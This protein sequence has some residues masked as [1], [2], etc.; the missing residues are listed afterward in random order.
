MKLGSLVFFLFILVLFSCGRQEAGLPPPNIVWITSEDNSKHYLELFDEDGVE[1]PNIEMLAEEG[2]IFRHAF[3]NAPVCSVARSTLISGTYSPRTGAQFHRKISKVPLPDSL[4]MFPAYLKEAGYYTANNSK[5]DYN[6]IKNEGVWDESSKTATYRNRRTGQPFFYVHN[7]GVSHESGLHFTAEQMDTTTTGSPAKASKVFPN[8]PETELFKFTNSF[9]RDK[10]QEMDRQVGAVVIQLKED[11]L[12][13]STIIFYFG[14]HGGVLPGS[15]GYLYE[16]GVHIPL[17][18]Y[19]PT[20]YR[21]SVSLPIGSSQDGFVSFIDFGP[22]VLNLAGIQVPDQMD[23]IPFLGAGVSAEQLSHRQLT[24]SYA[25]RFDEKYDMVRAVRKGKFKYIRNYQPFNFDGLM[26]NYRYK[27]LAYQQWDSLY[28]ADA[29]NPV[30]SAFFETKPPEMLYDLDQDPHETNNLA[31]SLEYQNQLS[32]MREQ[33]DQWVKGMPDLS[34]YPEHFLI[35][36]AFENP[37][38]FGRAHQNDIAKYIRTS[39]LALSPFKEVRKELR[40]SLSSQDPWERYWALIGCSTFG[41]EAGELLPYIEKASLEDSELINRARA[42]EYLGLTGQGNPVAVITEALYASEQ[43]AEALLI[44]N[45]IILMQ[46]ANYQFRFQLEPEKI[47]T[48]VK[49][50]AE[51]QRRLEFLAANIL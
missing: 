7:L 44:L 23:G 41:V 5:E 4:N 39:N 51:V 36:N 12:F 26:N 3:S 17:V 19:I 45:S 25:D 32:D 38:A 16:T 34:F 42:A 29:L 33:L 20:A 10:I 30:Q 18:V 28:R 15:K 8:H 49:E 22:T 31:T 46:S 50:N 35:E 2:V 24:F 13:D 43:P 27:M 1:T 9:Y 21:E 47:A 37:V 6:F 14:D 48:L 40:E 11:N